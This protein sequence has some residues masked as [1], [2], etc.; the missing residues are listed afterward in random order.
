M[1]QY[2]NFGKL[3][4]FGGRFGGSRP[5][6]ATGPLVGVWGE[7]MAA[8]SARWARIPE[9]VIRDGLVS[10]SDFRVYAALALLLHGRGYAA[11][12]HESIAQ[13]AFRS[14]STVQRSLRKLAAAGYV[15][16]LGGEPGAAKEWQLSAFEDARLPGVPHPAT[17]GHSSDRT[18]GHPDDSPSG[19]LGD[20]P[21]GHSSDRGTE[22]PASVGPTPV[23]S[24]T[25]EVGHLGARTLG[26]LGD[27]DLREEN[28]KRSLDASSGE[29]PEPPIPARP[30]AVISWAMLSEMLPARWLRGD[31]GLRSLSETF[32]R[33][34]L[35]NPGH[36]WF[37]SQLLRSPE[38]I[39]G[40]QVAPDPDF[41]SPSSS[42]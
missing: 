11:I 14:V 17:L 9:Q 10:D 12:S 1:C 16:D 23:T 24:L 32:E 13:L 21:S 20:I 40:W 29:T 4:R 28:K 15:V 8:R 19:H 42:V 35:R 25:G 37:G 41:W 22:N 6:G 39:G 18:P 38:T 36:P 2:P 7:V 31:A 30:P 33:E 27:V 26:H 5:L 3:L 34:V